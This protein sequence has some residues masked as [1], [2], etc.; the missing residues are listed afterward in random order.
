M[1]GWQG[2]LLPRDNIQSITVPIAKNRDGS[3]I[4]GPVME[5]LI[6]LLPNTTTVDLRTTQYVGLTYQV[7]S[8]STRR[9]RA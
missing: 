7:R 4:T 8:V 3:A 1:S 6:D 2:D 9:R 5:R